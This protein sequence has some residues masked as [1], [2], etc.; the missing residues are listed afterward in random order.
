MDETKS[1]RITRRRFLR[2]SG[3]AVA[4]ASLAGGGLVIERGSHTGKLPGMILRK[5]AAA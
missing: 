3:R 1:R 2:E 5:N 4:A